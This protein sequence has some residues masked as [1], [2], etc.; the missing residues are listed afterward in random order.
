MNEDKV[1]IFLEQR[2]V[3]KILI[4]LLKFK[5]SQILLSDKNATYL[6]SK[7]ISTLKLYLDNIKKQGH[8]ARQRETDA[9]SLTDYS[10]ILYQPKNYIIWYQSRWQHHYS[11]NKVCLHSAKT[12]QFSKVHGENFCQDCKTEKSAKLQKVKNAITCKKISSN[13]LGNCSLIL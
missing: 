9:A 3:A 12:R 13:I 8:C 10:T 7:N 5:F 4:S 2:Q 1:E 11:K 6:C